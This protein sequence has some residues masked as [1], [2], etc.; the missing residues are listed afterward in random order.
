[1]WFS[2]FEGGMFWFC[3]CTQCHTPR[4]SNERRADRPVIHRWTKLLFSSPD[5]LQGPV[6]LPGC[7][8]RWF[9]VT[10]SSITS[11]LL[12]C[13]GAS[14]FIGMCSYCRLQF[15]WE[16]GLPTGLTFRPPLAFLC[17]SIRA[18]VCKLYSCCLAKC[19]Q[20]IHHLPFQTNKTLFTFPS[21]GYRFGFTKGTGV[22]EVRTTVLPNLCMFWRE[23]C[24][25]FQLGWLC[26]VF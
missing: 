25:A 7:L 14:E 3:Q 18:A 5:S 16:S 15:Q 26:L 19:S 23:W 4:K 8:H 20:C 1:M 12:R 10:L 24:L 9:S 6:Q 22:R 21:Y 11:F 13:S 17:P 2:Q